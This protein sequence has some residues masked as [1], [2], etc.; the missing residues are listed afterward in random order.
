MLS[1]VSCLQRTVA[2]Q[3][4]S[5]FSNFSS[6]IIY[7]IIRTSVVDLVTP[8]LEVEFRVPTVSCNMAVSRSLLYSSGISITQYNGFLWCMDID[9]GI[10]SHSCFNN[11]FVEFRTTKQ[12]RQEI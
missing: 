9:L 11:S 3:C 6:L 12:L 1:L 5:V 7:P 8:R 2:L 10:I 4:A